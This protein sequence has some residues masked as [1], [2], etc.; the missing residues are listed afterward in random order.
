MRKKTGIFSC[1]A[2][3]LKIQ[4]HFV[5]ELLIKGLRTILQLN[6][7]KDNSAI[8]TIHVKKVEMKLLYEVSITKYIPLHYGTPN[9]ISHSIDSLPSYLPTLCIIYILYFHF[10]FLFVVRQPT[11]IA[12]MSSFERSRLRHREVHMFVQCQEL[13]SCRAKL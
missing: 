8:E 10:I 1:K 2:K 6:C 7:A 3:N 9:R 4:G 5:K 13:L 12:H 11:V